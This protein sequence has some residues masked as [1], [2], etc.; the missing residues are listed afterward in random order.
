MKLASHSGKN[1]KFIQKFNS[2][3]IH[4]FH[5]LVTQSLEAGCEVA[6]T[7]GVVSEAEHTAEQRQDGKEEDVEEGGERIV[8]PVRASRGPTVQAS[9]QA[10]RLMEKIPEF[11]LVCKIPVPTL[12]LD[13]TEN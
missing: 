3:K 13:R 10:G 5:L 11:G 6:P 4:N 9:T 7:A 2:P 8:G 1:L 12:L